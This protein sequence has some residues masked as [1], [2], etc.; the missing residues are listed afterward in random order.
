MGIS[1]GEDTARD[2]KEIMLNGPLH[3]SLSVPSRDFWKDIK[4]SLW[5]LDTKF[6]L[7]PII[8]QIP[9]LF[10]SLNVII[11]IEIQRFDGCPLGKGVDTGKRIL[12]KG[13]HLLEDLLWACYITQSEERR[14]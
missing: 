8:N 4:G 1:F 14:V 7:Q 3:K 11:D 9:L 13:D 6:F 10:V 2:K 5:F 12:L